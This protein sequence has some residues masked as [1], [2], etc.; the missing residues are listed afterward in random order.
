MSERELLEAW[1]RLRNQ[2]IFAQLAP[3]FLLITTVG[4]VGE[5]KSAGAFTVWATIG[6][7]LASGILGALV[8]YSAAHEAQAVAQDLAKLEKPSR[9]SSL[10][11]RNAVWLH[12]AK[13]LTPA[14]FVAIFVFLV[15]AL[16]G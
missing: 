7:L 5:I 16:L 14:I 6:I 13:Y 12:V 11:V 1:S 10:V 4:L 2:L 8:E 3:T 15:L 9:L